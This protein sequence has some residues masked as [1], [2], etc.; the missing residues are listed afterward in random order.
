MLK[1]IFSKDINQYMN[2]SLKPN[3][4]TLGKTLGP[5]LKE[6]SSKLSALNA[7]ETVKISFKMEIQL[8]L[9]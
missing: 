9:I 1:S 5:K 2:F 3:F 6:F 8:L 7:P 4:A